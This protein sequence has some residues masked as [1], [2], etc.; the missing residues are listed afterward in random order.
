MSRREHWRW[1]CARYRIVGGNPAGRCGA[2]LRVLIPATRFSATFPRRVA[3]TLL[4]H[5]RE[6]AAHGVENLRNLR[7][8]ERCPSS[9]RPIGTGT[10]RR[11]SV[12]VVTHS[13]EV[14]GVRRV[15]D[16]DGE[17]PVDS[18]YKR[19]PVADHPDGCGQARIRL[20]D[21]LGNVFANV[22][23]IP[24]RFAARFARVSIPRGALDPGPL[25][26]FRI[27]HAHAHSRG[28]RREEHVVMHSTV[29]DLLDQKLRC[30]DGHL[31]TIAS[32]P[33]RGIVNGG[34]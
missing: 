25:K 26:P 14:P 15:I 22:G 6:R 19:A 10:D 18:S 13:R 28:R 34:I 17:Q 12:A 16:R 11:S 27:D 5:L 4:E 3:Q 23:R 21:A 20:G 30:V 7:F 1:E 29:P 31:A 33:Q 32:R 8:L 2:S 24:G 9:R